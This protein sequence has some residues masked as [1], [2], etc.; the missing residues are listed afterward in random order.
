VS[1]HINTKESGNEN[2]NK[3]Q[4]KNNIYIAKNIKDYSIRIRDRINKKENNSFLEVNYICYRKCY[5]S[6]A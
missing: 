3:E 5:F 1:I 2:V 6:Y 4:E